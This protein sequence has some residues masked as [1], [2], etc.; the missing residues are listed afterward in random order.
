MTETQMHH[1]ICA[2]CDRTK[3]V[4]GTDKC[5][6]EKWKEA[7]K[8]DYVYVVTYYDKNETEPVVTAFSNADAAEQ[9]YRAFKDLHDVVSIDRAPIYK[10]FT[11][12]GGTEKNDNE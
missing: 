1:F 2:M 3:C 9:C 6:F 11:V 12:D 10:S 4:R 5:K 7:Q 8:V